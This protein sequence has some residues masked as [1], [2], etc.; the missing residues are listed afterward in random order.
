[1]IPKSGCRFSDKI[2]LKQNVETERT[3][4]RNS[5]PSRP[6]RTLSLRLRI[7]LLSRRAVRDEDGA[8]AIEYA[9]IAAGIGAA[10]AATVYSLGSTTAALYQSVAN[11]L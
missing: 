2:M 10:V 4:S 3:M 6:K 9:M 8:T 5:E 11:A 1:M 7:A